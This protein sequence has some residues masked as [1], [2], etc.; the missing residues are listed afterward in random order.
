VVE[1]GYFNNTVYFA[2]VTDAL[3]A[4]PVTGA[5]L[6]T[7]PSSQSTVHFGYP[8]ATPPSPP[9]ARPMELSG[10]CRTTPPVF[11]TR[12]MLPIWPPFYNSNQAANSSDQFADN[13]YITPVVTN[14]KVYV[15]TPNSVAVFGLLP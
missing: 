11:F 3:K 12:S 9:T 7:S 2:A 8:G 14:G 13:K 15:G 4:F 6:A 1:T 5:R 10:P